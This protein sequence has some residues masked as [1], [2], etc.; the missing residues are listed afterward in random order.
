MGCYSPGPSSHG[1]GWS[2]HWGLY[3]WG[4][5]GQGYHTLSPDTLTSPFRDSLCPSTLHLP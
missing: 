5:Q 2:S 3:T 4:P 1:G